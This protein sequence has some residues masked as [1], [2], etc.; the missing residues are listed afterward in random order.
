M[1]AQKLIRLFL[2]K[3]RANGSTSIAEKIIAFVKRDFKIWWAYKLWVTLDVLSTIFFVVT[4]FFV[5]K[6]VTVEHLEKAGF[7]AGDYFTF[8]MLGIA[9][10]Q[11]VFSSVQGLTES[12]RD[13]QWNGTIETVF[14]SATEYR[15]FMLG[16]S[17]FRFIYG[18]SFLTAALVF[19]LVL[20]AKLVITV[21][22]MLTITILSTLLVV[23]HVLVGL[24]G[25]GVILKLKRGDPIVWGFSW[26]SQ[27]V[28][29]VFYPLGLLPSYLRWIGL[30]FPLTY[31]LD[32]IRRCLI[33]GETLLSS[34]VIRT[35]LL[36]LLVF[37]ILAW[38][39][40]TLILKSGYRSAQKEGSLGQF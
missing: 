15:A 1:S 4:Y 14:A 5:G 8:A 26:M 30:T 17:V 23:D 27:L 11:Y 22:T 21:G 40:S 10:Q 20:G 3:R 28:S 6:I 19:G 32:G 16:E 13:E 2:E 34:Y 33:N 9:F 24:A 25:A 35:D 12:I 18:T 29:G 39:L 36:A 7:F 37:M 38:P 31:S